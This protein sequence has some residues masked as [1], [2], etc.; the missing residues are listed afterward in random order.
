MGLTQK[1]RL[2]LESKGFAVLFQ[3]HQ[4]VWTHLAEDAKGLMAQQILGRE[5]T[6]DDIKMLL[7]PILELNDNFRTFME[8]HPRL[9]QQFWPVYFTDYVLDR[10]YQ[11]ALRHPPQPPPAAPRGAHR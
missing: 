6:V 11:P 4:D 3:E 1:V 5:P 8:G 7:L 9:T 2:L 10:V